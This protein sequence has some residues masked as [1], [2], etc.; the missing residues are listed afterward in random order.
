MT[1]TEIEMLHV[2]SRLKSAFVVEYSGR[3]EK[4]WLVG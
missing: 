2:A 3:C 1:K 4:E